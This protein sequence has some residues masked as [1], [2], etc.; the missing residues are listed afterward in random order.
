[1][2]PATLFTDADNT[3]WDTDSVFAGAQ[4]ALLADVEAEAALRCADADRLAFVRRVDQALAERHHAGLRY[5]PRLLAQATSLAL[6]G[7]TPRQAVRLAIAGGVGSRRLSALVASAIEENF[8]AAIQRLPALRPGVREGLDQLHGRAC[9]ILIVTEGPRRKVQRIAAALGLDS[10]IDRI[11]ESPK[12]ADL[13]RRV[14]RLAGMP[15]R[16]LMVGD[17][18][19]RDIAPAKAAGLETIWFPS[20]FRPAWEPGVEEVRPDHVVACFSEVASISSHES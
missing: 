11:I 19:D 4:L 20:G 9:R 8:I 13:Y 12:R 14:L 2:P 10:F 6:A 3:L 1:M 5:P 15:G 17:Q 7:T 16:A 18:L